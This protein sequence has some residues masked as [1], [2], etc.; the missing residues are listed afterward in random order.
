MRAAKHVLFAIHEPGHQVR[1]VKRWSEVL[2]AARDSGWRVGATQHTYDENGN[3]LGSTEIQPRQI[4]EDFHE[5]A[6]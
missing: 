1:E 5:R 2:A 3:E 4:E 6:R